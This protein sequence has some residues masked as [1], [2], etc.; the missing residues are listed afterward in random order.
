M[1]KPILMENKE[2]SSDEKIKDVIRKLDRRA[3]GIGVIGLVV[4]L[5]FPIW[6]TDHF[7]FDYLKTG[8][9]GDTIGGLTAPIIGFF[10]ALLIYLSFRA[11]IKANYIVQSQI[12]RQEKSDREKKEI[13]LISNLML[14]FRAEI[15]E[16]SYFNYEG[17]FE[18]RQNVLHKGAEALKIYLRH[19]TSASE[20]YNK[21]EMEF[22]GFPTNQQY[23][24]LLD[25]L[26][27]LIQIIKRSNLKLSDK[28]YFKSQIK[29]L[30]DYKLALLSDHEL[31]LCDVCGQ[32]HIQ[33]PCILNDRLMAIDTRIDLLS[34]S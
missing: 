9:F 1:G 16:F 6:I 5:A 33:L 23:L 20:H 21:N 27:K 29:Y 26:D 13:E 18:N 30:F 24:G 8:T 2:Q 34:Q 32:P 12:E 11:Q 7:F 19:I 4:L 28:E 3:F 31:R 14:Q 25:I 22:L 10:S 15:N 17:T